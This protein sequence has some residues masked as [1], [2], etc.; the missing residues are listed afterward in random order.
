MFWKLRRS[1]AVIELQEQVS[2]FTWILS[3]YLDVFLSYIHQI[4]GILKPVSGFKQMFL[5]KSVESFTCV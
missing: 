3:G 1:I 2:F 4:P 5:L